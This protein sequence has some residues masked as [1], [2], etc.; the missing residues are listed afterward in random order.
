MLEVAAGEMDKGERLDSFLTRHIPEI[1]RSMAQNLLESGAVQWEGKTLKKNYRLNGNELF[2]IHLPPPQQTCIVPEEIPLSVIY[3]DKDII[4]INKP[5]GMVVHPAA[6][7]WTGTLVNALLYHCGESLSGIN[8]EIR[9]GIVHRID[10]DT[11]GLLVAAKNDRAH[12]GLA[13]QMKD[14]SAGRRYQ[15]VLLGSLP[16]ESGVIDKPI[17]RHRTDR[18][19]MAVFPDGRRAVTHYEILERYPGYTY[20]AFEL[21]TGRTHQIRVHMAS[22]GH[23]ILGDEVYGGKNNKW[24]LE[25]QCLHAGRLR[26]KHPITGEA[27]EFEAPLPEYFVEVLERL[28]RL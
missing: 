6:G 18:K 12:Q 14:H 1:T 7:N 23:P 2:L 9:P 24:K 5:K 4:V 15:A 22:I 8:G 27:M 13:E 20:A 21:K 28:R 11:S 3:E 10:K 26:L 19:K 17:A 16:N 25:G